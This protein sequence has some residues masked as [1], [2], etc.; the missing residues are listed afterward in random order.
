MAQRYWSTGVNMNPDRVLGPG[1][2]KRSRVWQIWLVDSD[3]ETHLA[4]VPG[5]PMAKRIAV[6]YWLGRRKP[7]RIELRRLGRVLVACSDYGDGL[8]CV[9]KAVPFGDERDLWFPVGEPD[10][11]F[12]C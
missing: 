2:V 9:T 4:Y 10:L 6:R 8:G 5:E 11:D 3:G 12:D 1:R 7:C